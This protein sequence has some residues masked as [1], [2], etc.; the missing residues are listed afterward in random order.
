MAAC[1]RQVFI[2]PTR[3][4][5]LYSS[6]N[7]YSREAKGLKKNKKSKTRT[8]AL[9]KPI[10][11]LTDQ[12]AARKTIYQHLLVEMLPKPTTPISANTGLWFVWGCACLPG[13]LYKK[14]T[15][16]AVFRHIYPATRKSSPN[17]FLQYIGGDSVSEP[18]YLRPAGWL[19]RV[20]RRLG[21]PPLHKLPVLLLERER[22]LLQ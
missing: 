20:S 3:L 14:V 17:A 4:Y 8:A 11:Y 7:Y 21:F 13:F 16:R 2:L 6:C 15:L 18:P 9:K 19:V 5:N 1:T 12:A 22:F 10:N